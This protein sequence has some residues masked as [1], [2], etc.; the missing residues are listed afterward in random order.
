[1]NTRLKQIIDEQHLLIS[2]LQAILREIMPQSTF[3]VMQ[4]LAQPG[5]ISAREE[6]TDC[7]NN[8]LTLHLG[9]WNTP[10]NKYANMYFDA[11]DVRFVTKVV[12]LWSTHGSIRQ[13][14]IASLCC[15]NPITFPLVVNQYGNYLALRYSKAQRLEISERC[16][17][18]LDYIADLLDN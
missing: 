18:I 17:T 4:P 6:T 12:W 11:Y 10:R 14:N 1:M 16:Y 13:H 7:P 3:R 5:S 15:Y 8:D 9:I 2:S